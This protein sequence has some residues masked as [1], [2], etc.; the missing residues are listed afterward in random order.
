MNILVKLPHDR[1][2]EGQVFLDGALLGRCR[3]KADGQM[4]AQKG[5]PTRDPRKAYGDHPNGTSKVFEVR[6]CTPEM[7]HSYG[8]YKL[9]LEGLDGDVKLREDAEPGWDGL[10]AHGG[11]PQADG[12]S[13]RATYGCLRLPNPICKAL[14]LAAKDALARGEEVIYE[15]VSV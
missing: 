12:V 4:A 11:D 6:E 13:L 5:N 7:A 2:G 15:C 1:I 3:G 8:P 9:C 14:A 10:E